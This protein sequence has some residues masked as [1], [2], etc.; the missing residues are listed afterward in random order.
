MI[1]KYSTFKNI[2]FTVFINVVNNMGKL[3]R[4]TSSKVDGNAVQPSKYDDLINV[5][6]T[7]ILK[8]KVLECALTEIV[9]E[10]SLNDKP[11]LPIEDDQ[12]MITGEGFQSSLRINDIKYIIASGVD[13]NIFISDSKK[14]KIKQAMNH[15][16]N[17][18][19]Q[20]QFIRISQ[21]V[22][23]NLKFIEK[24]SKCSN[25]NYLV[26]MTDISIPLIINRK[27]MEEIVAHNN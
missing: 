4:Q 5:L 25:D 22:I 18:L 7:K 13:I 14:V 20:D 19:P 26:N 27:N 16:E 23:I 17:I 6:E 9:K 1:V 8:Y 2:F 12:I 21:S 11:K 10:I 3:I 24:V 15:W